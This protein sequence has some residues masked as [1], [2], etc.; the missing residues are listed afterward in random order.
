MAF[1][2]GLC[3]Q[4][5]GEE[6]RMPSVATWWYG[7]EAPRRYVLDHL[8]ELVIKPA[9]PRFGREPEFP[10]TMEPERYDKLVLRIEAYPEEFVAQERIALST[11]PARAEN[12]IAPRHAVLRVYAAWDGQAYVVLPGGLTRVSTQDSSL[13]VSMHLGGGSKDTWV[14]SGSA[15][16]VSAR[17]QLRIQVPVQQSPGDL[18]SRV[19]DNFFWLAVTPNALKRVFVS[20]ARFVAGTFQ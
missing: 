9:F 13:V 16:A 20:S 11:V 7:Q 10:E 19:A 15:E 14:L 1:L 18:P 4:L 5:L 12:G 2:P 8:K 3:R 6:L 17:R